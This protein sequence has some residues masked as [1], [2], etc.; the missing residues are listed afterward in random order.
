MRA[1][2]IPDE[3]HYTPLKDDNG[4]QFFQDCSKNVGLTVS[5]HLSSI[6]SSY[7]RTIDLVDACIGTEV[8]SLIAR[9]LYSNGLPGHTKQSDSKAKFEKNENTE[10]LT[11]TELRIKSD[12]TVCLRHVTS[13]WLEISGRVCGSFVT[14]VSLICVSA[15][16]SLFK[17]LAKYLAIIYGETKTCV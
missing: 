13:I 1:L 17:Y 8:S 3:L 2:W 14:C 15:F 4:W 16:L 7:T 9:N 6:Y 10:N 5:L 12:S 11:A